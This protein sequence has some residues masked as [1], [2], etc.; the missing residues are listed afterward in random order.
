MLL[1][2]F[3]A[4]AVQMV[5]LPPQSFVQPMGVVQA[6]PGQGYPGYPQPLPG[7]GYPQPM[8]VPGQGYPQPM[9]VPGQGYAPVGHAHPIMVPSHEV[10]IVQQ[11]AGYAPVQTKAYPM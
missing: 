1:I 7:Q 6:T 2:R 8:P 3:P 5:A 9:P 4:V 10:Q 11:E